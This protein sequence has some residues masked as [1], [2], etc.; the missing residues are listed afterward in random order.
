MITV[1]ETAVSRKLFAHA[2]ILFDHPYQF[3]A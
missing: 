2:T 3:I 1:K